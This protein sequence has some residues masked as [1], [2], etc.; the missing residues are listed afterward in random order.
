[1]VLPSDLSEYTAAAF[2]PE[3]TLALRDTVRLADRGK[4][5]CHRVLADMD[6]LISDSPK[7]HFRR[8]DVVG[9]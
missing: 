5:T 1:V 6:I 4:G 8:P 7:L 9:L 3:M 2:L